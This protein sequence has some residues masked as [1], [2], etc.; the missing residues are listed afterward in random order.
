MYICAY[1]SLCTP[2]VC[3]CLGG[4]RALDPLE[5]ELDCCEFQVMPQLLLLTPSYE[6]GIQVS[7]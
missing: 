6:M 4:Q 7:T 1:V 2:Y 5:L 3:R